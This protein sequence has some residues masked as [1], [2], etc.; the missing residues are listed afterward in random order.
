MVT[1]AKRTLL[2]L[3]Y[4]LF[5]TLAGGNAGESSPIPA[6][7]IM[8]YAGM[9]APEG[10]FLCDGSLL[11][12][13]EYPE[14]FKAIGTH[15]GPAKNA[16][17]DFI[18]SE[19]EKK[20]LDT[21]DVAMEGRFRLPDFRGRFLRGANLESGSDLGVEERIPLGSGDMESVGSLQLD[22]T[23]LPNNGFA[24]S[25]GII[26]S[27]D[28]QIVRERVHGGTDAHRSF[29]RDPSSIDAAHRHHIIGGDV[30]TRPVNVSVNY[31]IKL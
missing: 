1:I 13:R 14:L 31:I 11:E 9:E 5:A 21:R 30:E 22:S 23:K 2:L 19:A 20:E 8:P 12:I 6:G 28:G 25:E 10:F 4:V 18:L 15:Y 16:A 26:A 7:V 24:T 17:G 29:I 27:I 3:F